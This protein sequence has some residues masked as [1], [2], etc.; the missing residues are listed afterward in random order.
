MTLSAPQGSVTFAGP[1]GSMT[2]PGPSQGSTADGTTEL[3]GK[4]ATP[5]TK[6]TK[7]RFCTSVAQ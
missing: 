1:Q 6:N 3:P 5:W 7:S 4:T 2:F